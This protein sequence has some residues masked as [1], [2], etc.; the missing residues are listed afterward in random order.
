M[1][2]QARGVRGVRLK[3]GDRVVSLAL[4]RDSGQ[5]LIVSA[6]GQGKRTPISRFRVTGRGG[7]GIMGMHRTA[8]TGDLVSLLPVQGTEEIMIISA[9]GTMIRTPVASISLQGRQS[10][11]VSVMRLGEAQ[12]VAAVAL[13][14]SEPDLVDVEET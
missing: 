4:V 5:L 3:V 13:I 10:Q 9:E 8:K 2:R 6:N 11:G 12:S 14:R 1:G 7:Q